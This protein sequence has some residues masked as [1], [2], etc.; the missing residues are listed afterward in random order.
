MISG[1]PCMAVP[2]AAGRSGGRLQL[3]GRFRRDPPMSGA[4][5]AKQRAHLFHARAA[6]GTRSAALADLLLGPRTG[7]DLRADLVLGDAVADADIHRRRPF[8]A[9]WSSR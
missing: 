1:S 2:P 7:G 8:R 4:R 3:E 5:G 6:P 9:G